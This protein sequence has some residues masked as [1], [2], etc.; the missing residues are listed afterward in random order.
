V[1]PSTQASASYWAVV[2]AND[3]HVRSGPSV[4][5]AYP[6]LKLDRGALVKVTEENVG[7]A[8]VPAIG[9]SFKESF[10]Y[11]K[12]DRKV[13]LSADGRTAE[14]LSTVDVLA[15]NHLARFAPD[16]SWK[17]IGQLE[18]GRTI[19]ILDTIEGQREKVH[20]IRLTEQ[21]EGWLNLT[22]LRP[23]TDQELLGIDPATGGER[24]APQAQPAGTQPQPAGPQAQPAG[25]SAQPT[26][27]K[28]ATPRR[29]A[30]EGASA[31]ITVLP[32][33]GAEG[34]IVERDTVEITEV[35]GG[36]ERA[37]SPSEATVAAPGTPGTPNTLVERIQRVTLAD[38]E[39]AMERL[40][41]EDPVTAEVGP[42]RLRFLEFAD[43]ADTTANQRQ[44][45]S[46][47]AEQ[48]AIQEEAQARLQQVQALLNRN[49][50]DLEILRN[51]RQSMDARQP[52]VAVGRLNASTVYDGVRLPLLFR[53]Q[54]PSGGQTIGYLEPGKGFDLTAMLGQL[55][56]IVGKQGYDSALRLNTIEPTRIDVLGVKR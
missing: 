50:A 23:A 40:R 17:S 11:V 9:P 45:A 46:A 4:D 15:P 7:W 31:T 14:V 56:G 42:L 28:P 13:R 8:R 51:A 44:F 49:N 36:S 52:Y 2:T 21:C 30:S 41:R 16:S 39:A 1:A 34:V 43:R 19:A 26:D 22:F 35:E 24:S 33:E 27:P 55:V 12:A 48:L 54:D 32:A 18:P 47:R 53:L 6:Y 5:A 10:G 38:L 29:P 37:A 20:K 25:P 3:V